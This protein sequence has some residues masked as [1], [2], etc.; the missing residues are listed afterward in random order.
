MD[1]ISDLDKFINA[2]ANEGLGEIQ[3]QIPYSM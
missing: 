3:W 2:N 1:F